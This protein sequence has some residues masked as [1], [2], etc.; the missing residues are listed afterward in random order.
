MTGTAS[1]L[2]MVLAQRPARVRMVKGFRFGLPFL[3]MTVVAGVFVLHVVAGRARTMVIPVSAYR[4]LPF[5]R[6]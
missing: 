4:W 2:H 1:Q 5:L 6:R 3:P